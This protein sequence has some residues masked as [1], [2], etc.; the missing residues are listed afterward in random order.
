MTFFKNII[1]IS[2]TYT[3][4]KTCLLSDGTKKTPRCKFLFHCSFRRVYNAS[5]IQRYLI[6]I[7]TE[8]PIQSEIWEKMNERIFRG[9]FFYLNHLL[10][11][12]KNLFSFVTIRLMYQIYSYTL[13]MEPSDVWGIVWYSIHV[14]VLCVCVLPSRHRIIRVFGGSS[15][16]LSLYLQSITR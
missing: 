3:M 9:K 7:S 13:E 16:R 14:P 8:N 10:R 11:G 12:E 2:V 5:S 6:H 15:L 4:Y 1:H